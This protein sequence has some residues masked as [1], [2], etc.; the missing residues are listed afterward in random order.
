MSDVSNTPSTRVSGVNTDRTRRDLMLST[1]RCAPENFS[2]GVI[3]LQP[4]GCHRRRNLIDTHGHFLA[5]VDRI[6]GSAKPVDLSVVTVV[7]EGVRNQLVAL[8]QLQQVSGV[9]K[10]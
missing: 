9:Q 10:E 6:C 5:K 8:L 2:L 7:R 1:K 3:Q 4:I